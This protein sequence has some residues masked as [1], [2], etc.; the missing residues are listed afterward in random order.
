MT[1][2]YKPRKLSSLINIK[3]FYEQRDADKSRIEEIK[4]LFIERLHQKIPIIDTPIII[5][6]DKNNDNCLRDKSNKRVNQCIVDGQHRVL[7]MFE[8]VKMNSK[9]KSLE[10]PC[11]IN[12]VSTIQEAKNIQYSLFNQK[13]VDLIDRCCKSTYSI[14]D[15]I[16]YCIDMIEK[17]LNDNNI[18]YMK[19]K[20][21]KYNECSKPQRFW[22]MISEFEHYIRNT[23]NVEKWI[24]K[25]ISGIELY[26]CI[27]RMAQDRK[28]ILTDNNYNK[29][30]RL[31]KE[32][33]IKSF[34]IKRKDN[35]LSYISY[36]YYKHY[37]QLI[38]DTEIELNIQELNESDEEYDSC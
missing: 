9:C 32:S 25:E 20:K 10:I 15:E 11:F 24:N 19:C 34:K 33:N 21:E 1:Q 26:N 38:S 30:L 4:N 23:P 35:L 8:L 6:E 28:D 17:Y 37:E 31:D 18:T 13:P 36:Y 7:A 16:R 2:L 22:F 14:G 3:P 5:V 12:M 29:V 27:L